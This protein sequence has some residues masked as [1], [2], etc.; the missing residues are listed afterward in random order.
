MIILL[1]P[2]KIWNLKLA[3]FIY[4]VEVNNGIAKI[5]YY[6]NEGPLNLWVYDLK[7]KIKLFDKI[8]EYRDIPLSTDNTIYKFD[9]FDHIASFSSDC[10]CVIKYA[11]P[12]S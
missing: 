9:G 8:L 2:L 1:L 6:V 4:D 7:N 3:L 5:I 12:N 10:N 11:L